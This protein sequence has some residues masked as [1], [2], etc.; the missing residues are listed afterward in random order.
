[1]TG[2]SHPPSDP[3][4]PPA[5]MIHVAPPPQPVP[6]NPE[7]GTET[8]DDGKA[9][10]PRP[11]TTV[12]LWMGPG[13]RM[14]ISF[15][16]SK[17]ILSN[18]KRMRGRWWHQDSLCWSVPWSDI[19]VGRLFQVFP[20]S[21]LEIDP[22]LFLERTGREIAARKFSP[23]TKKSYLH[24]NLGLLKKTG[25]LPGEITGKDMIDY[26]SG[27]SEGGASA[28]SINVAI[29]AFKFQYGTLMDRSVTDMI[30]RPRRGKRLPVVLS[31]GEVARVLERAPNLKY[32]ALFTLV[33]SSGLRVTEAVKLR[34]ND[35]DTER[36]AI[37]VR[38]GKGRKDR[39]VPLSPTCLTVI[40]DHRM[41]RAPEEWLFRGRGPGRHLSSRAVQATF[42]RASR[43]AGITRNASIHSLRHSYATHLLEHGTDIRVI[44]KLLGHNSSRTTEI[45][46]HVSQNLLSSVR[47]PLEY[48]DLD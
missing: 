38:E 8:A 25:K 36:M 15:T 34:V 13:R 23:N 19:D 17:E 32:R 45:Y 43:E 5:V 21:H 4:E 41:D 1:M 10:M 20:D 11:G 26:L 16:F 47:S 35:I 7:V 42:K 14:A 31:E 46:T 33:Y 9:D 6:V 40:D 12:R 29:S 24:Y 48:L 2:C 37:R 44:Q 27:M 3:G 18:V 22:L 28:S 30:K 39:D